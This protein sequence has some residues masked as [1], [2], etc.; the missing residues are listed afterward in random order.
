MRPI[1]RGTGLGRR[2]S[3]AVIDHAR[4]RSA[5]HVH[6]DTSA[7][8]MPAAVRLY[9]ALGFREMAA[10]DYTDVPGIVGMELVV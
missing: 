1:A 8:L 10:K 7:T 4:S 9:K 6:L 3:Q 2:L 5:T